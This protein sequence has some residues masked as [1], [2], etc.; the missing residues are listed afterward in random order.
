MKE[1][2]ARIV[3]ERISN[4]FVDAHSIADTKSGDITPSQEFRLDKIKEDLINLI[5]EQV[6]QNK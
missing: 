2:I 5:F 6:E 1:E 4:M 3:E